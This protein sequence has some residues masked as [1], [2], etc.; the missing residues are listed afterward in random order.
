M[1]PLALLVKHLFGLCMLTCDQLTERDY[2]ANRSIECVLV[3]D[4]D[5]AGVLV[6]NEE[7]FW[8]PCFLEKF[9]FP[10][11]LDE[12][13]RVHKLVNVYFELFDGL[14]RVRA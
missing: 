8:E 9:E 10:D 7:A 6:E 5:C 2:L 14:S 11:V 3:L 4:Y 13:P 12:P 1:L